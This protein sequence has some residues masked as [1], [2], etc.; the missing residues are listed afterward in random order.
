MSVTDI[1]DRTAGGIKKAFRLAFDNAEMPS[2][3]LTYEQARWRINECTETRYH[4]Q[5]LGLPE[6]PKLFLLCVEEGQFLAH[7]VTAGGGGRVSAVDD[8][9]DFCDAY[10]VYHLHARVIAP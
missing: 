7:I 1:F 10:I 4:Q 2:D 9:K 3:T 5:A 8:G 6:D